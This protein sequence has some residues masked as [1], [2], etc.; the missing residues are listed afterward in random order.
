MNSILKLCCRKK[1]FECKDKNQEKSIKQKCA[2]PTQKKQTRKRIQKHS[3]CSLNNKHIYKNTIL[4]AKNKDTQNT[5][6]N[7]THKRV[8]K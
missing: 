1:T 3:K 8:Q 7:H 2:M 5:K 6:G 4:F